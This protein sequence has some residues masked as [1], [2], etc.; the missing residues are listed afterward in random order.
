MPDQ[1]E[2]LE[3]SVNPAESQ[4]VLDLVGKQFAQSW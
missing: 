3:Q 4:F 2:W 1:F